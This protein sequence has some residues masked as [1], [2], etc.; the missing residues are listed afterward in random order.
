MTASNIGRGALVLAT[1]LF[2][3]SAGLQ[4]NDPDPLLWVLAYLAAA[5]CTG[6]AA[7]RR[8]LPWGATLAGALVALAGAAWLAWVVFFSGA[9]NP[10]YPGQEPTGWLIVDTEQGREMGGLAIIAAALLPLALHTRA[11]AGRVVESRDL[12]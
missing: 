5:A 3:A 10:M 4:L 1:T 11:H 6:L 7:F 8:P 2:V 9:S 12:P